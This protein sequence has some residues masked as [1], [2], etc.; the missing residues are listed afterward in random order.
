MFDWDA[1]LHNGMPYVQIG[2]SMTLYINSV[3]LLCIDSYLVCIFVTRC[4][5]FYYMCSAV[6]HARVAGLLARSQYLE[7]PATDLLGTGF[8]WFPS[9]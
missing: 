9:V 3:R 8:F 6:L 7:G 1:V 4:V 2:F 5:L